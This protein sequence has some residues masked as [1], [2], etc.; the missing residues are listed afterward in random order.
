MPLYHFQLRDGD[1]AVPAN[2]PREYPDLRAALAG[3]HG[4]ARALI[5]GQRLKGAPLAMRGS[6]DIEDERHEPVARILLADLE[7]QLS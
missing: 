3:A 1:Q 7:R 6:F 5:S 4:M 2:P